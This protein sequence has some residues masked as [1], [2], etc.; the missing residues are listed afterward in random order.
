MAFFYSLQSYGFPL[1]GVGLSVS[2]WMPCFKEAKTSSIFDVFAVKST[3]Y[4]IPCFL[5]DF[6]NQAGVPNDKE[7]YKT[8]F[9]E[10]FRNPF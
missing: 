8:S 5:P 9:F 7:N 3:F 10:L 6:V 4:E 2:W 1:A